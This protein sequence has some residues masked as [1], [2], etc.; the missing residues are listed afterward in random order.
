MK[1]FLATVVVSLLLPLSAVLPAVTQPDFEAERAGARMADEERLSFQTRY[2]WRPRLH[3]QSDI[4]MVYGVGQALPDRIKSWRDHGYRVHV[5]T[6]VAWGQYQDYFNGKWDGK[7]HRDQAQTD[8][9]GKIILHGKDTPYI[10]PSEDY[11]KYLTVGVQRAL[12]A[13][14][15]AIH[16]EEPEFWARAG[17]EEN[18]KREWRSYFGE[19][20]QPPH[21]STDAQYR[22]SKLKYLLYRRALTQV[23]DFVKDFAEK[24]GRTI[25]CYVP[26][27]SLLNY[28]HWRI[29]SPESSLI[30]VG[31]DGY[32]AQVW[33]G[34]ARTPNVYEGRKRERTFE[35][36]F[37]EYGAMQNLVRASGRRIWY[38]NDPVEDNANR[39]WQDFRTN[40]ENTLTASLMQ[41]EVWRYQTMAR[42]ERF[43][44]GAYGF[45]ADPKRGFKAA[46][47]PIPKSY[48]TEL[49]M[50]VRA[51]ADMKQPNSEVKWEQSGTLGAGVLV[52]DTMMFQRA[53]PNP[54]DPNLGSF[55][56]LALPLLM[57]GLPVEPVQIETA[58]KNGF[59][60]RYRL[61]LLTYEGQQ[62]PN[63]QFHDALAAWVRRGGALLVIDDD[64]DPYH[65]VKDWWNTPPQAYVTPRHHLFER[66]GLS[67]SATGLQ[68][69]GKGVVVR[70]AL[71]PAALTYRQDGADTVRQLAR[72]AAEGVRLPW[73]ETNALVLRRGPYL[74][75]AALNEPAPGQKSTRLN[76]RFI[77]LFDPELP[78]YRSINLIPGKRT[79]VL[80][81]DL[82]AVDMS[83]PRI[84]AAGCWVREEN[85][86]ADY[87]RFRAEGIENSEAVVRI[88]TPRPPTTVLVGG[89]PLLPPQY[90]VAEDTLLIRFT[91]SAAGVTVQ[92]RFD[93]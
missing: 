51:L 37:L 19:D 90:E 36:A 11:G 82:K 85:A 70:Q 41:P 42:P 28:A 75:G 4:A 39:S 69:V 1:A 5:M 3:V 50:V 30:D 67:P 74:I 78:V 59:L 12:D 84:L 91:N 86:T 89:K 34:T 14:A 64:G 60:D 35:T 58:T 15:E 83:I 46:R 71:S 62:P 80:L 38:L 73:K 16:L 65:S 49:Q 40:W 44:T 2:D 23:F 6:G 68:Q 24:S 18:F 32:I 77:N 57:R 13:G 20:W 63:P 47:V 26:T 79:S 55:Y 76:G 87:L 29:V 8:K 10:S 92:V 52:S 66:L 88:A 48:E 27:H 61:L 43:L 53:E 31:C 9:N 45:D 33:S 81:L 93:S 7:N 22:G 17:Y 72:Q 25:P 54:S 56:G 21:S